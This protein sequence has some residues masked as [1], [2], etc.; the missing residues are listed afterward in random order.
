MGLNETFTVADIHIPKIGK[1]MRT[2]KVAY[3]LILDI[4]E[5]NQ[6][7]TVVK[8]LVDNIYMYQKLERETETIILNNF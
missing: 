8:S 5:L 4:M 2:L 3:R 6:I 1:T 7:S